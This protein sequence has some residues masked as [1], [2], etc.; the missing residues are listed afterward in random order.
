MFSLKSCNVAIDCP[1]LN[2]A[3]APELK[4]HKLAISIGINQVDGELVKT[5][6]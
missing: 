6:N 5:Q 1:E 4:C 3:I 2:T